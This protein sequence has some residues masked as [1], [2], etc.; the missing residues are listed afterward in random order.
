MRKSNIGRN[1]TVAEFMISASRLNNNR[2]STLQVFE[3][4]VG[5]RTIT[6]TEVGTTGGQSETSTCSR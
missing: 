5:E 6:G 3:G 4:L 1:G 2:M